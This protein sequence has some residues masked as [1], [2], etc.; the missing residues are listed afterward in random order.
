MEFGGNAP[1]AETDS[2][3][4][5]DAEAVKQALEDKTGQPD[6]PIVLES[7]HPSPEDQSGTFRRWPVQS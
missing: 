2:F 4:D 3:D 7:L 6:A 1:A 5:V